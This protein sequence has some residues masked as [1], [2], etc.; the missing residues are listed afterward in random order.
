MLRDEKE[1]RRRPKPTPLNLPDCLWQLLA[2]DGHI[3]VGLFARYVDVFANSR[4][5]GFSC[6]RRH[7]NDRAF[8]V[9][10]ANDVEALL[11]ESRKCRANDQAAAKTYLYMRDISFLGLLFFTPRKNS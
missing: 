3:S 5:G 9:G 11:S 4:H 2:D 8:F 1:V 6:A 7:I 10:A